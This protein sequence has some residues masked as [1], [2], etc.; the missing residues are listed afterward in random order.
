MFKRTK[1]SLAA[2]TLIGGLGLVGSNV[3]AQVEQRVEITGS[4]IKRTSVEGPAPVEIITR[5][6]IERTGATS[7]NEL[8]TTI[9]SIDIFDQGELASNSPA[10]SGTASIRLRG[11]SEN[12]V[13]VLLNGRRL[14]VN[15]LYDSSGAGAA[16]DINSLPIGAIERVEILKDG[17][18]AIYGADAVAGVVNFITKTDYQGIEATLSLGD[19]SR[20]DGKETRLGLSA[21]F[22][23][24][25]KDRFNVL[26]GLDYLKRDPIYRKDRSISKSVD[27]RSV[28]GRDGRSSFAPSGNVIDPL[29]GGLVGVPYTACPAAN[30]GSGNI[31][32]YDFNSSLLTAYN[33]ADRLSALVVGSVQI[34]PSIKAFAEATYSTSKDHFEAHPVPDYFV[35]PITDASQAPYEVPLSDGV[36]A[37][38]VYVAGRFMQGGPRITDRKSDFLN[39]VTGVEG[40]FGT[41]DWKVNVGRGESKV[42]NTDHNYYDANLWVPAT[43]NGSLNPTVTTNNAAF[44]ES[45]KV[46]PV[47]VGKSTLSSLNLQLSGDLV[48]MPA[49]PLRF[50]VGASVNR[51]QLK[52]TPDALTQ[53]GEV[54]G[55][56]AQAAVDASRTYKAVFLELQVPVLKSLEAQLAV[57][58]DKYPNASATSPKV[59]A[60]WSIVPEFALRGSYTRS[61]R[62]PVLKQLYGAREEGA[63]TI[64]DPDQCTA[65]GVALNSGGTCTIAAFQ[66]NGSNPD[67]HPEKGTTLNFGTVFE[68]A[69]D[70]N[71]SV[72]W[73]RIQKTD[74][75]TSPTIASAIDAGLFR[76]VGPRLEIFTTLQNI[77]ERETSGV[78][79]D[80]RWRLPGTVIGNVTVRDL[81]TYYDTNKTRSTK[82]DPWA[83]YIDT[84]VTPRFRNALN[85]TSE[86][87][88]WTYGGTWRT[89]GGFWD[90]DVSKPVKAGTRRVGVHEELDLLLQYEGVKN[91]TLSLGMKNALDRMPPLSL[92][93]A[94]SNTYTQMGFAEMYSARGR[95]FYLAAKYAF[96]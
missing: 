88:P 96:R 18:S 70:F 4:A 89:V 44:V 78:D 29:T 49:G 82:S 91:L 40:S 5:K 9:P 13:L 32:R 84:Y 43:S 22:G 20:N 15:A 6:Q 2:A 19:S 31:C 1:V 36:G 90:T 30:L 35:M 3:Y 26:F 39:L 87:G 46:S 63:T 12:E 21:G 75:I 27:F 42:T 45:L 50:A 68:V 25:T 92:T 76:R 48:P 60:K 16:F 79:V 67:L 65:L 62:A 86:L 71:A 81:A 11:L 95:Y 73:W 72:D 52:D 61:F 17:A 37:G 57:R 83:E 47:R 94:T 58:Y 23:D 24:L 85:I 64:T 34:T 10:G 51:E 53:A 38:K 74:D 59:G 7:I 14:P 41:F 55:S 66:V 56:I 80:A 33:G 8:L 69:K 77:A 28:G 54:V 93:N